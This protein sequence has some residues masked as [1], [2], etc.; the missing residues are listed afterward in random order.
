MPALPSYEW[1]R[2]QEAGARAMAS[3]APDLA[4]RHE[5][6][7][8]A[9]AYALAARARDMVDWVKREQQGGG[10]SITCAEVLS[11]LMEE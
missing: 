1:L 2:D 4:L 11:A 7:A 6:T 3:A 9:E 8:R 5:W 10:C